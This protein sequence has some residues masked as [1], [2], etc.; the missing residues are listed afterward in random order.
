VACAIADK[1]CTNPTALYNGSPCPW[2]SALTEDSLSS[3]SRIS[4]TTGAIVGIAIGCVGLLIIVIVVFVVLSKRM[5][6][7]QEIV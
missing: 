5:S 2:S 3:N 1:E 7:K 6:Q 4:L